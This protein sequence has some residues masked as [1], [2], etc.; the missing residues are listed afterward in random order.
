MAK[1]NFDLPTPNVE[2]SVKPAE[3]T[4]SGKGQKNVATKK[5]NAKNRKPIGRVFRDIISEL[6]K[7][8]WAKFK[9]TKASKGVLAQ[10]GT[11]LL[12]V[13]VF[14]ILITAMDIGLSELL[15]LLIGAAAA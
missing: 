8:D 9:S 15:N 7:V 11:V 14:I 4:A 2:P 6:K 13:V 5:A 3:E 1:K 12:I 10:T